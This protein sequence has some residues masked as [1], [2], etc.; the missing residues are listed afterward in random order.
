M[1]I[2]SVPA[3]EARIDDWPAT[4]WLSPVL[5]VTGRSVPRRPYLLL[6]STFEEP[7]IGA[8]C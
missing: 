6:T 5:S 7:A 4:Y 2:V 8:K 3:V 1:T